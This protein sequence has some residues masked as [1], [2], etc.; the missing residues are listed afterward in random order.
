MKKFNQIIML[1][2]LI[3]IP[4]YL[5]S[6][7]TV[8]QPSFPIS[9]E[10]GNPLK[11]SFESLFSPSCYGD[12]NGSIDIN[13]SGGTPPYTYDWDNDGTG[14]NDDPEDL[15]NISAGNY[16]V[17][18]MDAAANTANL[19]TTLTEPSDLDLS[20][21]LA[22]AVTCYG[23]SQGY[24]S[25]FP[26]GGTP[27][28]TYDWDN[29]GIGDND[30][31]QGIEGLSAGTYSLTLTD[32]NGC[33]I[34][35]SR[36]VYSL[37]PLALVWYTITPA[38]ASD[39]GKAPSTLI[40]DPTIDPAL[41]DFEHDEDFLNYNEYLWSNGDTYRYTDLA[42]GTYSVTVTLDGSGCTAVSTVTVPEDCTICRDDLLLENTMTSPLYR[43]YE[44][45]TSYGTVPSGNA[46]DFKA[47]EAV[48]LQNGFKVEPQ[49]AFS[50]EIEDCN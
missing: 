39:N 23:T 13:V 30:D 25:V 24:L 50:A 40:N 20:A 38:C 33:T 18:I 14:D 44:S 45:I 4:A 28:Y 16:S 41:Y 10:S 8:L 32:A 37:S 42:A 2:V 21:P 46:V 12:S 1:L 35:H 3:S 6:L 11:V 43:V 17:S 19:D 27:P 48:I 47:G 22:A 29:D 9:I 31:A 36:T 7:H 26:S 34:N 5:F 15:Q 49:A